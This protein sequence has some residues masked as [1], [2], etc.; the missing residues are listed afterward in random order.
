M[1]R[2]DHLEC[3]TFRIV[4]KDDVRLKFKGTL[5]PGSKSAIRDLLCS[6][7]ED[8]RIAHDGYSGSD[9]EDVEMV[10]ERAW[11]YDFHA[12]IKYHHAPWRGDKVVA[13]QEH[14]R[15]D[16]LQRLFRN[17]QLAK[18]I[19]LLADLEMSEVLDE[20]PHRG[21]VHLLYSPGEVGGITKPTAG[22]IVPEECHRLDDV[23]RQETLRVLRKQH[24]PRQR[25]PGT[26]GEA[27]VFKQLGHIGI[28]WIHCPFRRQAVV[29]L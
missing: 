17:L 23:H 26:V 5:N 11:A 29:A 10:R 8:H 15:Y 19:E 9:L 20:E 3:K 2:D 21:L 16:F 24:R 7:R 25:E 13:M 6:M 14:V 28:A 27:K 12:I 1:T 18:L 22:R 4:F